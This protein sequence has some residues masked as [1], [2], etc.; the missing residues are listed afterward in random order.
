M[1]ASEAAALPSEPE[2][3]LFADDLTAD[4]GDNLMEDF[5]DDLTEDVELSRMLSDE[6]DLEVISMKGEKDDLDEETVLEKPE[7]QGAQLGPSTEARRLKEA[8]ESRQPSVD[9]V[10]DTNDIDDLD[11]DLENLIGSESDAGFEDVDDAGS[12]A[13]DV[14]MEE[15]ASIALS[16]R[17]GRA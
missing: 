7:T 17:P 8:L 16:S 12:D 4:L 15:F 9:E 1:E 13:G 14:D 3:E 10:G 2:A 5:A 6:E 11:L